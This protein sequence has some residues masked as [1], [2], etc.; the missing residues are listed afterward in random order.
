MV[1]LSTFL[2]LPKGYAQVS[3]NY[4]FSTSAGTYIPATGTTLVAAATG[5]TPGSTAALDIGSYAIILPFTFTYNGTSYTSCYANTNGYITFGSIAPPLTEDPALSST[6]GFDGAIAAMGTNLWGLFTSRGTRTNGSP[7]LTGVY[8]FTG[9]SVGMPINFSGAPLG[10]TVIA[11]DTAAQTIT[12]SANATSSSTNDFINWPV[13]E[14][15]TAIAGITPNRTFI[16]QYKNMSDSNNIGGAASRLNFQIQLD[17]GGGIPSQQKIRIV[18]GSCSTI[19][20]NPINNQIGLRGTSNTD[21]NNRMSTSGWSNTIAGTAN[22]SV[23]QRSTSLRPVSGLTYIWTPYFC[24]DPFAKFNYTITDTVWRNTPKTFTASGFRSIRNYWD[25]VGHSSSSKAGPYVPYTAIR[26]CKNSQGITACFLDTNLYNNT[27]THTFTQ[28]GYYLVKITSLNACINDSYIDTIFVD[29]TSQIKPIADFTIDKYEVS[30]YDAIQCTD[31]SLNTPTKWKWY[32]V[33]QTPYL[34]STNPGISFYSDT[35]QNPY[36]GIQT[37]GLFDLCLIASNNG[38]SDTLCRKN[39]IR[40]TPAYIVCAGQSA[41]KDTLAD[42]MEG[43]ATL[44]TVGGSYLPSLIGTCGKGFTVNTCADTVV[45]TIKK[46][47]MRINVIGTQADS[48]L[49]HKGN[50]TGPVIARLGGTTLPV[51]YQTIAVPGGKFFLETKL[52][53]FTGFTSDSGY[54]ISWKVLPSTSLLATGHLAAVSSTLPVVSTSSQTSTIKAISTSFAAQQIFFSEIAHTKSTTGQ[55]IAGWPTYLKADDYVE[56][57]GYPYSDIVGYTMEEWT[58]AG[59]QSSVTF[60]LGTV[61]SP[62]GTMIL[63]TGQLGISTP[64]PSNYYYH[65]GNTTTHNP[66]GDPRGYILKNPSGIIVDAVAYD[67]YTFAVAS[68]VTATHWT[69]STPAIVSS[70]NRLNAPDNNTGSCWIN[71]GVSPQDP[72]ILNTGVNNPV[73]STVPGFC[74]L[75]SGSVISFSPHTVVGPYSTP[76]IYQYVASYGC[77]TFFDTLK[78]TASAT[79]PVK[80]VQF[81]A[82]KDNADVLLSWKTA[83]EINS[84]R[85]S[86]E[87]SLNGKKYEPIGTV[88]AAGT[89]SRVLNYSKKDESILET[90]WDSP[91]INQLYY[92]LK[93]IDNDGSYEY[94]NIAVIALEKAE[95]KAFSIVPNPFNDN[96]NLNIYASRDGSAAIDI[97]D[98]TGKTILSYTQDVKQGNAAYRLHQPELLK[99]GIY[100]VNIELDGKRQIAKLMKQ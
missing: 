5:V 74:W 35:L 14:I 8:P 24:T 22:N 1:S 83:S 27:L 71:S 38:G 15:T 86:V 16:I 43:I 75:Y 93:M 18:Y 4:I 41:R 45:L 94:S 68:G 40:V 29:N 49:I 73:P 63:A 7:V 95:T 84:N 80:L 96:V 58:N 61:F 56:L 23:I 59:L 21:F 54:S 48:L 52:A 32:V 91:A 53:N 89:S 67:A 100:F 85:F 34:P 3:T 97:I 42:N 87:R 51:A 36:L 13:G 98:I 47:R 64:S 12:L 37:T 70:G 69:G 82:A 78:I 20:S 99:P 25:V 11:I 30:Q 44:A 6:M 57:T 88:K 66:T 17:E 92:R 9:L 77:G 90:T 60:P 62:A 76:G 72:N 79:V 46:F 50:K 55:P 31:Q 10:T 26:Q 2:I 39:I 33:P 19:S 81:T 65:S 28:V